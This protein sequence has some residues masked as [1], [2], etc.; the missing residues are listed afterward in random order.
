[1]AVVYETKDNSAVFAGTTIT[2]IGAT[3]AG[4]NRAAIVTLIVSNNA[5]TGITCSL[6][7]VNGTLISGTDST[8]TNATRTMAFSVIAPPLGVQAATCSWTGSSDGFIGM[9]QV[10]GADQATPLNGGTFNI[11]SA[12]TT[13]AVTITSVNGDLT[14]SAVRGN[15]STTTDQTEK[16]Q[17]Y[18][19]T[20][21]D[22]GPGTGT[23]THTWTDTSGLIAVVGA[24]FV[25]ASTSGV[26]IGVGT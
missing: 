12:S 4:S 20:R 3:I 15:T 25:S 17:Q 16:W 8:T 2:T 23:T 11:V 6:G 9:I 24:N 18:V 19:T 13:S 21:G 1:M 5:I 7:G 10:T 26:R 22:V 14:T